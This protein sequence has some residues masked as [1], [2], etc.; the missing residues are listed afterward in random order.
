[1]GLALDES[2]PVN[3]TDGIRVLLRLDG[4]TRNDDVSADLALL[5]VERAIPIRRFLAWPGKRNYEGLCSRARCA[6]T[7]RSSRCWSAST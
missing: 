3:S 6:H 2:F 1:V 4:T 5:P 7:C